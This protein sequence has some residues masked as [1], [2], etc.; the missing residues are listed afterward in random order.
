MKHSF[1]GIKFRLTYLI[2]AGILLFT[3]CKKDL[4]PTCDPGVLVAGYESNGENTVAK[5]WVNGT[6]VVLSD[7]TR[8][9]KANS[10]FAAG[11]NVYAAGEDG[12][13]VYWKNGA[14]I[15]LTHIGSSATAN[16]IYISGSNI[17]I[18][19]T[20]NFKAVYWKNGTEII[21]NGTQATSVFVTHGDVYI[22]GQDI[23]LPV[24]WKN[25]A[26]VVLTPTV[27]YGEI[28]N[29]IYVSAS[30]VHTVGFVFGP[31]TQPVYWKNGI[32][33][34]LGSGFPGLA[35]AVF[36]SGSDVYAAGE[37]ADPSIF[38]G[39]FDAVYWK[40]GIEIK[41]TTGAPSSGRGNSIYVSAGNIY[42]AGYY[43]SGVAGTTQTA[44]YWKNTT[45]IDLT[46]GSRNAAATSV[47]IR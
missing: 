34:S 33:G 27:V 25:G 22:A 26:K 29:S 40:N 38:T 46:D 17:Y 35:E 12:G 32:R 3:S 1:I 5:C 36:V 45:K 20:D 6:E 39:R 28:A 31:I 23:N 11:T 42:T 4:P 41:L 13:P 24:Y 10:I 14:E 8:N 21:L 2:V 15:P 44:C 16:S 9:A 18:A 47:F 37:Q 19:G 43:S 30:D 7:G